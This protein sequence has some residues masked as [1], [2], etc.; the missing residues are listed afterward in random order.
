MKKPRERTAQARIPG[1]CWALDSGNRMKTVSGRG[2]GQ[3]SQLPEESRQPGGTEGLGG[4]T[5]APEGRLREDH[6]WGRSDLG[7]AT[8][9]PHVG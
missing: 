5:R 9:G 2:L 4:E 7:P 8:I 6:C 3:V 1:R